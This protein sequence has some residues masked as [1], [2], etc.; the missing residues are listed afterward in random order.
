MTKEI[1]YLEEL[2]LK[3]NQKQKAE[4]SRFYYQSSQVKEIANELDDHRIELVKRLVTVEDHLGIDTGPLEGESMSL[5]GKPL[6]GVEGSLARR[7]MENSHQSFY[8]SKDQI[9]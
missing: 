7:G 2:I 4:N 1:H 8:N 6:E 3:A 5:S 9:V